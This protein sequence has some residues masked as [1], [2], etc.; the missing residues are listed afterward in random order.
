MNILWS[1]L[2]VLAIFTVFNCREP[3]V[4]TCLFTFIY[5]I[6]WFK[7]RFYLKNWIFTFNENLTAFW[8]T[9][10]KNLMKVTR[11]GKWKSPLLTA[12]LTYVQSNIT[13]SQPPP[14]L[15]PSDMQ[16]STSSSKMKTNKQQKTGLWTQL[17]LLSEI[18]LNSLFFFKI[19]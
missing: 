7:K 19:L 13:A 9:S 10:A 11:E 15:A 4:Y 2:R 18:H 17:F 6:S 1:C 16:P 5:N 8:A 3:S 14:C 12:D